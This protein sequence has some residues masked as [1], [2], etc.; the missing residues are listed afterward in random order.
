MKLFNQAS[1]HVPKSAYLLRKF[2]ESI[3]KQTT[4]EHVPLSWSGSD[5]KQVCYFTLKSV[6]EMLLRDVGIFFFFV[7][8]CFVCEFV[9]EI[10][11]FII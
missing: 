3:Y 5:G 2:E 8:L 1:V 9:I 11:L 6:L 7:V 10:I 4:I